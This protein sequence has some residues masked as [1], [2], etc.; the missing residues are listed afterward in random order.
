M[1][2]YSTLCYSYPYYFEYFIAKPA[3]LQ[4]KPLSLLFQKD[5]CVL[6]LHLALQHSAQ[7]RHPV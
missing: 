4:E 6:I 3:L 7:C 1:C 5:Y 2:N